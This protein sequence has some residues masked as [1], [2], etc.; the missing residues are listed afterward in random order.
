M[1]TL[2]ELPVIISAIY[3]SSSPLTQ[4]WFDGGS[5]ADSPELSENLSTVTLAQESSSGSTL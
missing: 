2:E 1:Y 4:F 3:Y 5:F